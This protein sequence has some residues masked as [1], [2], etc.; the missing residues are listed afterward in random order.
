MAERRTSSSREVGSAGAGVRERV[1]EAA[2]AAI[3]RAQAERG[4]T[5]SQARDTADGAPEKARATAKATAEKAQQVTGKV[6]QAAQ[7]VAQKAQQAAQPV[8]EK[9][10]EV[11]DRIGGQVRQQVDQRSSEAG[12]QLLATS[13]ALRKSGHELQSGG[14]N[15]PAQLINQV[16]DRSERLASYLR[17]SDGDKILSDI[18]GLARSQPWVAIAGGIVA[19]FAAARFLKASS[20]R[21]F[22]ASSGSELSRRENHG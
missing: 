12:A 16:A 10:Q 7:P 13:S 18:E 11:G 5:R 15:L 4:A 22:E 2:A 6:E 21:R 17:T 9:A 8:V 14:Q 20:A 1:E 3:E 19:G